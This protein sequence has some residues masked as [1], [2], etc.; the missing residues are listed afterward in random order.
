[1][2]CPLFLELPP[3]LTATDLLKT[4]RAAGIVPVPCPHRKGRQEWVCARGRVSFRLS[5]YS[6]NGH[7][8]ATFSADLSGWTWWNFPIV[9]LLS[10][11]FTRR[12]VKL[13][14]DA[15]FALRRVGAIRLFGGDVLGLRHYG[16]PPRT[17]VAGL[18]ATHPQRKTTNSLPKP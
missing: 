6:A 7:N 11:P 2:S 3:E 18:P 1:M 16:S 14:R 10:I 8:R 15:F 12:E 5:V 13:Q 9:W 17:A 4:L